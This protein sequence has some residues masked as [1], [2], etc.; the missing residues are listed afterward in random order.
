MRD[1]V[2]YKTS[3]WKLS[4][5]RRYLTFTDGFKAGTFKLWGSRNLHFYQI[6]QIKRVTVVRRDDS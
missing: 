1:S 3:G 5:D 6:K 4:E 2:E